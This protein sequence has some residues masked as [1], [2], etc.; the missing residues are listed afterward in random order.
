MAD[1]ASPPNLMAYLFAKDVVLQS[2]R[3][4]LVGSWEGQG[5]QELLTAMATI[6]KH[7]PRLV[8][9]FLPVSKQDIDKEDEDTQV[10]EDSRH[11]KVRVSQVGFVLDTDHNNFYNLRPSTNLSRIQATYIFITQLRN[12]YTRDYRVGNVLDFRAKRLQQRKRFGFTD[13]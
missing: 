12:A 5:Y 4:G 8:N 9:S 13:S 2:I 10:F 1:V 6:E 3:L 11:R 7:Y